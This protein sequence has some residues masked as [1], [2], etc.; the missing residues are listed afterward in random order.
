MNQD[1]KNLNAIRKFS[2]SVSILETSPLMLKRGLFSICVLFLAVSWCHASDIFP[3]PTCLRVHGWL[4]M[5]V[6]DKAGTN[7]LQLRVRQASII[8]S[9]Q[10][11]SIQLDSFKSYTRGDYAKAA[12]DTKEGQNLLK[13]T[14]MTASSGE[15]KLVSVPDPLSSAV[16]AY[17][18]VQWYYT[19]AF[20]EGFMAPGAANVG[21]STIGYGAFPACKDLSGVQPLWAAYY[22]S[23]KMLSSNG[24]AELPMISCSPVSTFY[25]LFN[26]RIL[27]QTVTN[28][29]TPD[30]LDAIHFV[31]DKAWTQTGPIPAPPPYQ[32]G[33]ALGEMKFDKYER[34][35][36]WNIPVEFTFLERK[37]GIPKN[38]GQPLMFVTYKT[39]FKT[40]SV[41]VED[42]EQ[43]RASFV[44]TITG[45]QHIQD[46]R[47]EDTDVPITYM[48]TNMWLQTNSPRVVQ[49]YQI[50]K[51]A[52]P[53]KTTALPRQGHPK[54]FNPQLVR[55]F[56]FAMLLIPLILGIGIW[57][58]KYK[59]QKGKIKL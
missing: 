23:F 22:L 36:A 29:N 20:S 53:F 39:S 4:E 26:A 38:G 35:G 9:K 6:L 55:T 37:I 41:S 16:Y 42:T 21:A 15:M 13:R 19:S 30:I 44:P 50:A 25:S 33:Y 17:D 5:Q 27:I 28:T 31:T 1:G 32:D 59:Q 45:V 49:E 3:M 58:K 54:L 12:Y 48:A 47:F 24:V 56:F 7:A 2:S 10:R 18:G 34:H 52:R 43:D 14:G 40:T 51:R 8:V 57:L 11:W 46:L